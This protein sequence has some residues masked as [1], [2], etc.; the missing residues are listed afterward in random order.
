[1][2]LRLVKKVTEAS[3]TVSFFWKPEKNIEYL[4]GQF[5]Y[6]TL[7]KL[8]YPDSRGSTRHFTISSSPT[9]GE[10]IRLTTRIRHESGFK[11]TL[12]ELKTGTEIEGEGPNGTFILDKE[13]MEPQIFLAG[14]IGIT[15]FRSIIK[16]SIDKGFNSPIYLIYSNS[17]PEEIVFR[18]ELEKWSKAYPNFKLVLTI[19]T[20]Q[21]SQEK[22]LGQ[23]GR[24]DESLLKSLIEN[25]KLKIGNCTWWVC[26]PPVMV[27]AMEDLLENIKIPPNNVISEKLSGY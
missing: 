11:K 6:F 12:S 4:P 26:G 9:E 25:W 20:P 5:F 17:L 18:K 24:I 22:W 10:V 15:P 7:P 27:S 23:T 21:E 8:T 13:V 1:M 14:G 19:S 2:K 3:G 16:Y